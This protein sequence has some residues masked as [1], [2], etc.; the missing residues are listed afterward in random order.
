MPANF[1]LLS[2]SILQGLFYIITL[3]FVIF[4]T[5]TVYHWFT[6]G[7]SKSIS[8]L[9]FGIYLAGSAPLFIIMSIALSLL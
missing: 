4:S 8:M 9:S 2:F 7:S 3:V 6:Y 5:F 1:D